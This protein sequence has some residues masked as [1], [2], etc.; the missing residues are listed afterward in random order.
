MKTQ[1]ESP[2]AVS[3]ASSK[4]LQLLRKSLRQ[5]AASILP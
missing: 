2:S 4:T 3:G 5:L 1:S